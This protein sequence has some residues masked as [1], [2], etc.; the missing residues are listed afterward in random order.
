MLT[1]VSIFSNDVGLSTCEMNSRKDRI[2][3]I[4]GL[5]APKNTSLRRGSPRS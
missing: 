3:N 5:S 2:T 1:F 4:A